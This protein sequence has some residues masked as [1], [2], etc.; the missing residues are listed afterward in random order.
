V[1]Y[2]IRVEGRRRHPGVLR[3]LLPHV[4]RAL[5]GAVRLSRVSGRIVRQLTLT[6]AALC[7]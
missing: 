1:D 2:P 6:A 3:P 4:P 7:P 5:E